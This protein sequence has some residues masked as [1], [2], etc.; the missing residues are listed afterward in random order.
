MKELKRFI[1]KNQ[2]LV[3]IIIVLLG[4][5]LIILSVHMPTPNSQSI[6]MSIGTSFF[7][8][9]IV[10][11]ITSLLMENEEEEEKL[12]KWGIEAIYS[13]RGEMNVSCDKYMRKAKRIDIIA[14][15]LRSWRDSQGKQIEKLL[16]NGCQIRILTMDP[17]CENLKQRE[18]DEKQ[19]I[20]SIKYTIEQLIKWANLMNSRKYRGSIKIKIYD[21]QPLNFMFLMDN[22]LF[23]GPYEYGKG[24]QQTI[25]YEFNTAE[26]AYKYYTEYFQ[27]LWED[28]SFSSLVD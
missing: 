19:E 16:K 23:I 7:A 24:S 14:F 8:S 12:S 18:K 11:L 22:R 27:N 17:E 3:N 9:G 15:G 21:A 5:I 26:E 4:V 6:W 25:S 1:R 10:V 20:G 13:T 28:N 2:S